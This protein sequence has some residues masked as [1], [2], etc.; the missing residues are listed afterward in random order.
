MLRKSIRFLCCVKAIYDVWNCFHF[1]SRINFKCECH[2]MYATSSK[3]V[4]GNGILH[5]CPEKIITA[6]MVS[7]VLSKDVLHKSHALR[8]PLGIDNSSSHLHSK[9][10]SFTYQFMLN[11]HKPMVHCGNGIRKP[12]KGMFI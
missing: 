2:H 9:A 8:G 3:S 4:F 12:A 7:P 11:H 10:V 1:L 5:R 6:F